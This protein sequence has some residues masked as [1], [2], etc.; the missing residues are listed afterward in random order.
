MVREITYTV[1]K[2]TK[3]IVP[4]TKQWAGM[5]Y[6]DNATKVIFDLSELITTLDAAKTYKYRIDFNSSSAGYDPSGELK[7]SDNKISREIPAKFT[8]YGGEIQITAVI[9]E[10]DDSMVCY[11]FPVTVFFTA[12]KK[13]AFSEAEIVKN[14]SA[15]EE[16]LKEFAED[17][18]EEIEATV[19]N[20]EAE[21]KTEVEVAKSDIQT[22]AKNARANIDNDVR[23]FQSYSEKQKRDIDERATKANEAADISET[24]KNDAKKSA[25]SAQK[26]ALSAEETYLATVELRDE[27]KTSAPKIYSGT[28]VGSYGSSSDDHSDIFVDNPDVVNAKIG[29]LYINTDTHRIYQ[30]VEVIVSDLVTILHWKSLNIEG[31][32]EIA[33]KITDLFVDNE[34]LGKKQ[35]PTA[36]AVKT[37]TDEKVLEAVSGKED[38]GNKVDDLK[39]PDYALVGKYPSALAV[40]DL[41]SVM[42]E[43]SQ[44]EIDRKL[45]FKV[46][47]EEVANAIKSTAE[48]NPILLNDVSPIEHTLD[49]S[50]SQVEGVTVKTCGKNLLG[51]EDSEYT[52]SNG[53]FTTTVKDGEINFYAHGAAGF[54]GLTSFEY[55]K[56]TTL[57]K[58]EYMFSCEVLE[59]NTNKSDDDLN[60][61]I[62]VEEPD[63]TMTYFYS[64]SKGYSGQFELL[65]GGKITN[66]QQDNSIKKDMSFKVRLQLE[67]NKEVT[68]YEKYVDV[69][70]YKPNINGKV[71]NVISVS[72]NMTIFTDTE[73]VNIEVEY[74]QDADK[75]VKNKVDKEEGKTLYR[76]M[77]LINKYTFTGK[78]TSVEIKINKDTNGNAFSLDEVVVFFDYGAQVTLDEDAYTYANAANTSALCMHYTYKG[79]TGRYYQAYGKRCANGFW[80][81]QA[82]ATIASNLYNGGFYG[83]YSIS[84]ADYINSLTI[85]AGIIQAG[86][87]ITV[88]GRRVD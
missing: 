54:T 25:E 77:E 9:T 28:R 19:N 8:Q 47:K 32:E 88:Y 55:V 56:N 40:S 73:G 75:T 79:R 83:A 84:G 50:V 51:I 31:K 20:A 12:V 5:Q 49:V 15:M 1:T 81:V 82:F 60:F 18:K 33:N 2:D 64:E 16:E 58:G 23:E 41:V 65:N 57:P 53:Y 70:E 46:D 63:G 26:S 14:I 11:S 86:A 17:K 34:S 59:N 4:A 30:C 35:Y 74:N 13:E 43:G 52:N 37:Y 3:G 66:V 24:A 42:Y 44:A 39:Q 22:A 36:L 38:T 69:V 78:E 71:E 76:G 87:K 27:V 6:E 62:Q 7:V 29:D 85:C 61:R 80:L 10:K 67:L 72:P 48:G 68:E 21:I 45:G